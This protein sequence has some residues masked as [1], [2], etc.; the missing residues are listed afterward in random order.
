MG[1]VILAHLHAD[2]IRK[3]M[4][5]CLFVA[6]CLSASKRVNR[7][8]SS[9]HF[10]RRW[11]Y[12]IGLRENRRALV[13]VVCWMLISHNQKIYDKRI[14]FLRIRLR[15]T[16]IFKIIKRVWLIFTAYQL[17]RGYSVPIGYCYVLARNLVPFSHI[18]VAI[19]W[20]IFLSHDPMEYSNL[21]ITIIC[22][23]DVTLTGTTHFRLE[24]TWE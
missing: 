19:S 20:D 11:R 16:I 24:W 15:R 7:K 21:K 1:K 18:P 12:C 23:I 8:L 10:P 22:P 13:N 3:K 4:S 9:L 5:F 17:L 2:K 14:L 6:K